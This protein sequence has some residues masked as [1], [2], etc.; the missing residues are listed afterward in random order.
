LEHPPKPPAGPRDRVFLRLALVLLVASLVVIGIGV[1]LLLR[2]PSDTPVARPTP[3]PTRAPTPE[4]LRPATPAPMGAVAVSSSA[5][6]SSVLV[7]GRRI[8]PAPQ[9][10]D[11]EPGAHSVRVEKKGF[12]TFERKVQIVPGRTLKIDARL[13]AVAPRLRVVADVEGAQVFLDRK[14]VGEAPVT[15]RDVAPGSHRLNV[16]AEGYEMYAEDLEIASGT[17]E[18][19]IKFKEVRLDEAIEVKHKHGIGSCRGRLVATT[20]GLRYETDHKKDGFTA[21]F[22]TLEPLEVDYLDKNLRVK[23]RGGRKY[24]F[25]SENADDLLVFQ[26]AVEAARAR[27]Q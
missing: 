5:P 7:D 22:S 6:G 13:K 27:L 12:R 8:G 9:T 15:V 14:F 20:D 10:I 11:L 25:T 21:A 26:K 24:N 2:A 1:W 4:P 16:S 3:A 19:V 18:V 23:I 17:H